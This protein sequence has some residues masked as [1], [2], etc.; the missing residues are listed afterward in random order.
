[1]NVFV[2]VLLSLLLIAL[3]LSLVA[4]WPHATALHVVATCV[5]LALVIYDRSPPR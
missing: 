1:M 2:M 3:A 5:I 4:A